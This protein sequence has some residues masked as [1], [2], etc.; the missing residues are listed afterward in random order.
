MPRDPAAWLLDIRSAAAAIRDAVRGADRKRFD[1]E[2]IWRSGIERQLFIIGEAMWQL[3]LVASEVSQRISEH[4]R[5]IGFRHILVHGYYKLDADVVWVI[6][7]TKL[8]LLIQEVD[9]LLREHGMDPA[10][11]AHD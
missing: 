9:V 2:L 4:E 3:D 1:S 8:D 5:I 6:A 11:P 10:R 7:T